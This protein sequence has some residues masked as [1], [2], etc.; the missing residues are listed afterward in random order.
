MEFGRHV[1]A[2]V[3]FTLVDNDQTGSK[4]DTFFAWAYDASEQIGSQ[5][6]S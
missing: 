5:R 1:P 6:K 2:G 3:W 4:Y